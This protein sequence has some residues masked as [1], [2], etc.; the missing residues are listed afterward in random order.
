MESQEGA[1]FYDTA[2]VTIVGATVLG[3]NNRPVSAWPRAMARSVTASE[4]VP[5]ETVFRG[6]ALFAAR[7]ITVTLPNVGALHARSTLLIKN[8]GTDVVTIA[9]S[10]GQTVEGAAT[11]ALQAGQGVTL[12]TS[13]PTTWRAVGRY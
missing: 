2:T 11:I 1:H 4:R 6:Q 10:A 12:M 3:L 8:T 9:A 7:A 5:Q 13:S